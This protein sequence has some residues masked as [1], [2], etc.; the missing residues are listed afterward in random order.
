MEQD[1][2][3]GK[4]RCFAENAAGKTSERGTRRVMGDRWEEVE[5]RKF[6]VEN[7]KGFRL[8]GNPVWACTLGGLGP[9]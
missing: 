3:G 1:T 9:A 2:G 7:K 4:A 8:R 6:K 5:S